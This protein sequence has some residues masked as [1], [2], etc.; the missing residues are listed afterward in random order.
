MQYICYQET[1]QPTG[2]ENLDFR[3][4][5]GVFELNAADVLS[6]L[7]KSRKTMLSHWPD[8]KHANRC[9]EALE[10]LIPETVDESLVPL[11]DTLIEGLS[12]VASFLIPKRK[13]RNAFCPKCE[14]WYPSTDIRTYEWS[15]G[16]FLG[17][18]GGDRYVCQVDHTLYS[19]M[20]WQS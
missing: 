5:P 4:F 13:Y 9:I 6:H 15:F 14:K 12:I 7:H 3:V 17:A 8:L 1:Q 10:R 11:D 16:D 2:Y 19:L 18:C 20:Y